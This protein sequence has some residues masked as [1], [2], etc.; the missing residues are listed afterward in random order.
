MPTCL[1]TLDALAPT[2]R[3]R[4]GDATEI[5]DD[6]AMAAHVSDQ[7]AG[8]VDQVIVSLDAI[9]SATPDDVKTLT[10]FLWSLRMEGANPAVV[11]SVFDVVDACRALK[12][13]QAFPLEPSRDAAAARLAADG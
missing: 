4:L 1:L 2:C 9:A 7:V 6:V 3:G 5:L 11:C 8:G 10:A 13:D 12:L